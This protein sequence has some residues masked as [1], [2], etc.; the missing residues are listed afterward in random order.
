MQMFV[1]FYKLDLMFYQGL[2]SDRW[3][4]AAAQR[5]VAD[6]V[7]TDGWSGSPRADRVAHEAT[8][9]GLRDRAGHPVWSVE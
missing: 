6:A 5:A 1:F 2:S 9:S 3:Q 8:P 7:G 4:V